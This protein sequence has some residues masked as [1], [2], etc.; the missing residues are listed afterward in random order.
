MSG[1]SLD[2]IDLS[3]INTDGEDVF[4]YIKTY[5]FKYPDLIIKKLNK[6]INEFEIDKKKIYIVEL[7]NLVTSFYSKKILKIPEL[8][9]IDLVVFMAKQFIAILKLK[10]A[11]NLDHPNYF[12]II[13]KNLI[14]I[15][16]QWFKS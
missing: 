10:K 13:K 2:G 8:K 12:Q 14:L 11:Y 3:I 7:S 1:T 4:K 16:G 5:Y 6:A 9:F 15:L